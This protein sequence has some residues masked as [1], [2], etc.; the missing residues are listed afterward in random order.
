MKS[1]I[2]CIGVPG[3]KMPLTPMSRSFGMSTSGMIPPTTTSTSSNPFSFSSSI[4]PRADV[5]VRAGQD[6]QPDG[7]GV[8][9]QRRRHDLLRRLTQAGVDHFHARVA[10][11]ARDHLG[12]AVVAVEAR[13]S[14]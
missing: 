8:L 3:R 13:A 2:S 10:Q 14:R 6:R 5:H 1:M 11:R 12:A 7:I 9:L 4:T